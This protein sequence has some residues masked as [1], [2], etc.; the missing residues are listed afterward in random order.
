MDLKW[1]VEQFVNTHTSALL[2]KCLI[3]I[4]TFKS[5]KLN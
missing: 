1:A 4:L 5:S 2:G 3:G